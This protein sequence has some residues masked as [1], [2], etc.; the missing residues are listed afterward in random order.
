MESQLPVTNRQVVVV[1][2]PEE[3][4]TRPNRFVV[5]SFPKPPSARRSE[6]FVCLPPA[7]FKNRSPSR[8]E[9]SGRKRR[10]TSHGYAREVCQFNPN[11]NGVGAHADGVAV[12]H[13][14]RGR[15]RYNK[16]TASDQPDRVAFEQRVS[17]CASPAQGVVA[18]LRRS[19]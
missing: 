13:L 11:A 10:D 1:L 19:C 4:V 6:V 5:R 18:I 9:Q 14:I 8:S 12:K 3:L 2:A 16:A 7:L 17:R 15:A